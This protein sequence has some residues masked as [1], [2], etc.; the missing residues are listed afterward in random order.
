MEILEFQPE[1]LRTLI[2]NE[3]ISYIKPEVENPEYA[4]ALAKGGAHT[5]VINGQIMCCAGIYKLGRNRW[6]AW[7]LLSEDSG[8][9]ML[10]IT[11]AAIEIMANYRKPRLETHVRDDFAQGH[12]FVDL[13]GF[14]CETPYGMRNYGDDGHDYYLYSRCA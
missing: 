6:H 7:A 4:K 9:Y 1:H 11:R 8:P 14:S 12:K 2:V 5:A 10:P 3:Y 13:L